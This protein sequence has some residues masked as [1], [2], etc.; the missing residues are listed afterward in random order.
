MYNFF[1]QILVSFILLIA[2]LTALGQNQKDDKLQVFYDRIKQA[3]VKYCKDKTLLLPDCTQCIPGLEK[4]TGSVTCDQY[5]KE[6]VAIRNE[7]GKLTE[8]R[9]GA[10]ALKSSRPFGLYPYLEGKSFIIRQELF[11]TMLSDQ[12][13]MNILDVGAYYNPINLFLKS[14]FCPASLIVVEPILNALSVIVPCPSSPGSSTHFIFLPITFKF[15]LKIK[16]FVPKSDSIV[17]IGCD[18]HYGPNRFLLG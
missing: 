18:S 7:I 11:G 5:V 2:V 1:D 3:D 16:N 15:Y 17:C 12:K 14:D 4:S 8:E 6:S 13:A 10:A 9:Y